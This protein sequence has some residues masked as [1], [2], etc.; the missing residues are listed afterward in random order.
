MTKKQ[1]GLVCEHCGK[2]MKTIEVI[3]EGTDGRLDLGKN[4]EYVARD[5]ESED[6]EYTLVCGN[7]DCLEE[8]DWLDGETVDKLIMIHCESKP[9]SSYT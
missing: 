5:C 6:M 7:S 9:R 4:G 2:T 1:K 8:I 3:V